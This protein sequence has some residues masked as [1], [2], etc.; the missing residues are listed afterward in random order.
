[1]ND[2]AFNVMYVRLCFL[3]PAAAELVH[4]KGINNLRLLGGLDVNHVNSLVKIIHRP[5]RSDIGSDVSETTEHNLILVCHICKYWRQ[6]S[7]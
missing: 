3:A 6:T 2:V 7:R 1:M 4:T 5:D